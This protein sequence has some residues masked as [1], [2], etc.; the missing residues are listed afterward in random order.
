M[1]AAAARA[2]LSMQYCMPL[3][4]EGG[5]KERERERDQER[6]PWSVS[7]LGS[8]TECEQERHRGCGGW[9]GDR[10]CERERERKGERERR[11]RILRE[12]LRER[13][14]FSSPVALP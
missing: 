2:G 14:R 5:E 4:G 3:V 10:V 6:W 12:T 8:L 11:E 1:A 7:L 13:R 9:R